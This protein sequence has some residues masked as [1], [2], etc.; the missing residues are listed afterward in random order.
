[1]D[2]T[3]HY[4]CVLYHCSRVL[5]NFPFPSRAPCRQTDPN[6]GNFLYDP[7]TRTLNLIDFGAARSY[8]KSFVDSYIRMVRLLV[9][10]TFAW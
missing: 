3:T 2:P 8:P 6:W 1:M 4:F 9:G 7:E 5:D 10:R